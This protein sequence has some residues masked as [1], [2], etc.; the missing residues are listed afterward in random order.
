ME[1]TLEF[2]KRHLRAA[3]PDRWEAIAQDTGVAKTLP[4]KVAYG[5]RPNPG[6]QTVQP[7]VDYF[8]QVDR[9]QRVL[10]QKRSDRAA[11]K[12]PD[13]RDPTRPSPYA[14]TDLDRRAPANP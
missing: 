12:E 4:R 8:L 13:R 11:A 5:D 14:G 6:I 7:L 9:G 1:S 2:L 10:P 3:G